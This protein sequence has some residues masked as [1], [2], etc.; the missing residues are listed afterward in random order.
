MGSEMCIRDRSLKHRALLPELRAL[1]RYRY[2]SSGLEARQSGS[3]SAG[4]R[5]GPGKNDTIL[6][7]DVAAAGTGG[8]LGRRLNRSTMMGC[9]SCL[10]AGTGPVSILVR[11]VDKWCPPRVITVEFDVVYR[12]V[13]PKGGVLF[14]CTPV[15]KRLS[16]N[17]KK[18]FPRVCSCGGACCSWGVCYHPCYTVVFSISKGIT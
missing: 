13:F 5:D 12:R 17:K 18:L 16:K 8:V 10:H 9:S 3:T 2:P 7:C 11:V 4:K 1:H 6:A 14:K 15:I